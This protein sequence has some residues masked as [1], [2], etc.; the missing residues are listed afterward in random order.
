MNPHLTPSLLAS[1]QLANSKGTLYT[2]PTGFRTIIESIQYYNTTAGALTVDTYIHDG[3]SRQ[4]DS[5]SV[6]A[7]SRYIALDK[8]APYFLD[9][10]DLLQGNTSAATS[11]NYHVFGWEEQRG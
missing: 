3:T 2:C 10:A 7:N 6:D 5:H 8:N 11:V 1:G 4:T 9:A